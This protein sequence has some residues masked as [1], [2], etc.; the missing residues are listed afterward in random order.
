[1]KQAGLVEIAF[2]ADLDLQDIY[3]SLSDNNSEGISNSETNKYVLIRRMA[4]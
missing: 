1:M 2:L 4:S 3:G